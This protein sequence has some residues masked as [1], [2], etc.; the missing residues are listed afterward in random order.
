MN[1]TRK[2]EI[3]RRRAIDILNGM[4]VKYPKN[5]I[6][7]FKGECKKG[8]KPVTVSCSWY[9]KVGRPDGK[10]AQKKNIMDGPPE[11]QNIAYEEALKI[12]E[13][14][15]TNWFLNLNYV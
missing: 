6:I 7:V 4:Q 1:N 8:E 13:M 3:K 5:S 2:K 9:N 12:A 15:D 11:W 14:F 10:S